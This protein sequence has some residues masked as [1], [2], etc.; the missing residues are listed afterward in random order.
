MC[1]S[2]VVIFRAETASEKLVA[3]QPPALAVG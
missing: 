1:R 3:I 2:E